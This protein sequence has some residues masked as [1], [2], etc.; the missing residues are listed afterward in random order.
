[1][2]DKRGLPTPSWQGAQLAAGRLAVLEPTA[3]PVRAGRSQ[4]GWH[5]SAGCAHT[6][7]RA[8]G[9]GFVSGCS[10]SDGNGDTDCSRQIWSRWK[11]RASEGKSETKRELS[12][13]RKGRER[14][15]GRKVDRLAGRNKYV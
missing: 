1:M 12:Q 14:E 5:V 13:E 4:T 6:L 2:G 8:V 15:V 3:A 9:G 10:K 7:H 11:S